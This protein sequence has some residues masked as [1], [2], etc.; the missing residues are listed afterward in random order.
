MQEQD[1]PDLSPQQQQVR[2]MGATFF[3]CFDTPDGKDVLEQLR[4]DVKM[5]H[6]FAP[7]EADDQVVMCPLKLAMRA[8]R[9]SVII[10]IL[11]WIGKGSPDE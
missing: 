10:M 3:R 11:D 2:R 9:Q 7:E 1:Q 5:N 4:R 6:A 8:G